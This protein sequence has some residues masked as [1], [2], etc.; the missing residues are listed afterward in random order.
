MRQHNRSRRHVRP[1]AA[2]SRP[3][4]RRPALHLPVRIPRALRV[5]GYAL[6]SYLLGMVTLKVILALC[7]AL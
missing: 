2:L 5:A 4:F 7:G 3:I 6:G 1:S